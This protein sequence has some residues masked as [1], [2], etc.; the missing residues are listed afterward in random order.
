MLE[1]GLPILLVT[2]SYL[3][4]ISHTLTALDVLT[5]RKVRIRAI[6]VSES[7]HDPVDLQETAND[8]AR[9]AKRIEVVALPRRHQGQDLDG[10]F[11]RIA[12]SL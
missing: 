5:S 4:T 2:G 11:A 10:A 8:I 12:H 7:A 9:F 3:G 1:L 6:V